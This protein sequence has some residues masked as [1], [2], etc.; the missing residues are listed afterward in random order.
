MSLFKVRANRTM[1]ARSVSIASSIQA[2]SG[3][4]FRPRKMP[5]KRMARRR[6]V[7][8]AGE[9]AFRASTFLACSKLNFPLG[10]M[11]S[12]AAM[13]GDIACPVSGSRTGPRIW[14]SPMGPPCSCFSALRHPPK[15]RCRFDR[16]PSYPRSWIRENSAFLNRPLFAGGCLRHVMRP[17]LMCRLCI[18][19][20]FCFCWWDV[21]VRLKWAPIVEPIDPFEGFHS[22]AA[23]FSHGPSRQ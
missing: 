23:M 1:G 20:L 22:T 5:L 4:A 14:G 13:T 16:L 11:Q 8:K 6:I 15:C 19:H 12:A 10:L 9:P 7:V 3:S 17:Y 18:V 21:S 2:G